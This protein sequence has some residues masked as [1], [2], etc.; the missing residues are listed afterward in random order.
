ML[1]D[2][3]GIVNY[4]ELKTNKSGQWPDVNFKAYENLA[5]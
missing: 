4:R 2:H 5:S 1:S 3:I